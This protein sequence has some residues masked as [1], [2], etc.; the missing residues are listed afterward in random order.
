MR[1]RPA[2]A[3]W[4][5][6]LLQSTLFWSQVLMFTMMLGNWS[7]ASNPL[8]IP[9]SDLPILGS[10]LLALYIVGILLL[11][12]RAIRGLPSTPVWAYRLLI[13]SVLWIAAYFEF[14]VLAM[15]IPALSLPWLVGSISVFGYLG[16]LT[17]VIGAL[18]V[19]LAH[20]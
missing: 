14:M 17:A 3:S 6:R 11:I 12:L 4:W 13:A 20:V 9:P 19:I 16:M 8:R 10:C 7:V 5:R 1:E 15:N 18:T 2:I